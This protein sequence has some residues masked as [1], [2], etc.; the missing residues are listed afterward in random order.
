MDAVKFLKDFY[1]MCGQYNGCAGCPLQ[2]TSAK[3]QLSCHEF[4]RRL[5]NRVVNIVEKWSK[6]HPQKTRLDDFREKF[7]HFIPNEIG[8]PQMLPKSLGYC[9]AQNC[10]DCDYFEEQTRSIKDMPDWGCWDLP[11]DEEM[12]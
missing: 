10:L 7:P 1:R 9:G 8:Y 12:P 11:V 2:L 6:E 3:K 5:P 4:Q